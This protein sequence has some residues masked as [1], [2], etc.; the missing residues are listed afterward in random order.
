MASEN[1][2]S[3]LEDYR[4]EMDLHGA[5]TLES[6]INSH[7]HLRT[8]NLER[9]QE[10]QAEVKK[11]YDAGYTNGRA[12]AIEYDFLSRDALRSMTLAELAAILHED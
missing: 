2:L 9:H 1:D 3:L 7:R 6:L 5:L 4:Q 12:Q 11:G 8:L 10:W